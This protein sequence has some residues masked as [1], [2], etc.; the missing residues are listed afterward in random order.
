MGADPL[1]DYE[2]Q[3]NRSPSASPRRKSFG[4]IEREEDEDE[5]GQEEEET[6]HETPSRDKGKRKAALYEDVENEIAEELEN[7]ELRSDSD[8]DQEVEESQPPVKKT[9]TDSKNQKG[10]TQSKGKKENIGMLLS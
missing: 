7:V 3:E 6:P 2:P 8:D 4:G 5:G 10:K 1:E 9:K